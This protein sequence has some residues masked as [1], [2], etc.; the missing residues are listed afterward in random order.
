MNHN[1]LAQLAK[2][3]KAEL[4]I[5]FG[6]SSKNNLKEFAARSL[7]IEKQAKFVEGLLRE[8]LRFIENQDG[9]IAGDV[10]S[11]KPMVQSSDKVPFLQRGTTH[12][13][14]AQDELQELD[15]FQDRV[16][17]IGAGTSALLQPI[18]QF[19]NESGLTS[20]SLSGENHEALASLNAKE[21]LG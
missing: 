11:D 12:A 14:I 9:Q 20:A 7:E 17:D 4:V 5:E 19:V 8:S 15:R 6:L 16:E 10:A 13:E 2:R 3:G 21:K 18:E 1:A